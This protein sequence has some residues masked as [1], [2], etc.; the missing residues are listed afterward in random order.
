MAEKVKSYEVGFKFKANLNQ[1]KKIKEQINGFRS[2]QL[3]QAER[4]LKR[5]SR[6]EKDSSNH[7]DALRK[8]E[9]KGIKGNI[10]KKDKLSS[11]SNKKEISEQRKT[12]ARKNAI[13]SKNLRKRFKEEQKLEEQSRKASV[14]R[15]V[16]AVNRITQKSSPVSGK[17]RKV[18]KRE[19]PVDASSTVL[20][21]KLRKELELVKKI[22]AE[23][24]KQKVDK[25]VS[26]VDKITSSGQSDTVR[27]KNTA[28]YAKMEAAAQARI[29]NSVRKQARDREAIVRRIQN[30]YYYMKQSES[31]LEKTMQ[32][33]IKNILLEGKTA[34]EIK[35]R[36][37]IEKTA[38]RD[39]KKYEQS[40]KRRK[41]LLDRL[42]TSAKQLAGNMVGAFA[43]FQASKSIMRSARDMQS[44]RVAMDSVSNSVE[45]GGENFK[46][47]RSEAYRLG[48]DLKGAARGFSQIL[49]A[50]QGKY[51][52]DQ[53]RDIFSGVTEAATAMH[54]SQE[55][56]NGTIIAIQQMMSKG[57]VQAQEL[58]LQL[59][60]RLSPAF[61][62]FAKA[63]GV[64]TQQLDKLMQQG[65]VFSSEVL[66]KFAK[67]LHMFAASGLE[68]AMKTWVVQMGRMR[69][70]MVDASDQMVN[71]SAAGDGLVDLF[72]SIMS[73]F[74][75]NKG[76]WVGLGNLIGSL[77]HIL[78]AGI[79]IVTPILQVFGDTL[80]LATK[81]L[82]GFSVALIIPLAGIFKLRGAMWALAT[83]E[84]AAFDTAKV[85]TFF[86]MLKAQIAIISAKLAPFIALYGVMD[87]LSNSF[88][89]KKQGLMSQGAT[90][91]TLMKDHPFLSAL[92]LLA[93]PQGTTM[94]SAL[95]N[96]NFSGKY[97]RGELQSNNNQSQPM[98]T[99]N[100][101]G[102]GNTTTTP[103]PQ[104]TVNIDGEE[105]SSHVVRSDQMKQAVDDRI[106]HKIGG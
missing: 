14:R 92:G 69:T 46:W 93:A 57:K 102:G 33:R 9:I 106:D 35:R 43:V 79:K 40:L 24:K 90:L 52:T 1:L 68:A 27:A 65:K 89:G 37:A 29:S 34:E 19:I 94:V 45:E 81:L 80:N 74:K 30:S 98:P 28:Y 21:D 104:V 49:A 60:N 61:R 77:L 67:Q 47:V 38:F 75:K 44:F 87:E 100:N 82:G 97:F 59:G 11:D 95:Q 25:T 6:A 78:A 5:I 103:Q 3:S 36:V 63:M 62:L 88:T 58:R 84:A 4:T 73:F 50:G 76:T 66:P 101:Q 99:Q 7:S 17:V 91:P 53:M 72:G 83:A 2:F 32:T 41:F 18:P 23:R 42:S 48:L 31:E 51:T 85:M 96:A 54:L 86:T 16:D 39:T 20:A 13:L 71:M 64:S 70:S 56:V 12:I 15:T 22:N 10:S 55:D 105:V 8:N 26:S